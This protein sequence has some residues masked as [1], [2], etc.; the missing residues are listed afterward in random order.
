MNSTK[1]EDLAMDQYKHLASADKDRPYWVGE[2]G[3]PRPFDEMLYYHTRDGRW[4]CCQPNVS[5][6]SFASNMPRVLPGE[7]D[8]P[9]IPEEYHR[10]WKKGDR[11]L[12]RDG[13]TESWGLRTLS[14]GTIEHV[15]L[16]AHRRMI[17]VPPNAWG[18]ED[19]ESDWYN[20]ISEA[21]KERTLDGVRA[22]GRNAARAVVERNVDIFNKAFRSE[23]KT[24]ITGHVDEERVFHPDHVCP[25]CNSAYDDKL[26][27]HCGYPGLKQIEEVAEDKPVH[28]GYRD[29]VKHRHWRAIGDGLADCILWKNRISSTFQHIRVG[30]A[31][32]GD[33]EGIA[34]IDELTRSCE[35]FGKALAAAFQNHENKM[36]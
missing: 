2:D 35:D 12:W 24:T 29:G 6:P 17:Y 33:I 32:M 34:A 8:C 11:Y 22:M 20:G 13:D 4:Y 31:G 9:P 36:R 3:R 25:R 28:P 1:C 10:E 30:C 16:G 15:S 27:G 5:V 21:E 7:P 23:E 18:E 19:K 14:R 26:C